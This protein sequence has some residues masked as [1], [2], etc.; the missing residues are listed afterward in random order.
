MRAVAKRLCLLFL[1]CWGLGSVLA[2]CSGAEEESSLPHKW[3][4]RPM[5]IM[6]G[7][8]YIDVGWPVNVLPEGYG[9]VGD[10]TEE[11]AFNT[12][13]AGK[14]MYAAAAGG[15][16]EDFY[17]YQECGTP[18]SEDTIDGT[19]RQWAYMQWILLEE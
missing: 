13:L 4:V 8:K 19:K 15:D 16:R 18:V 11:E 7:K 2:G 14:R 17:L 1:L 5:I 9:Y 10:L 6:D 3:D 12:D